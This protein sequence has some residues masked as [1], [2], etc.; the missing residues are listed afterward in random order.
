MGRTTWQMFAHLCMMLLANTQEHIR[1]FRVWF[2]LRKRTNKDVYLFLEGPVY[3]E[4]VWIFGI[5]KELGIQ[6]AF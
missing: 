2:S 6:P 5:G 3:K 1:L 4:I